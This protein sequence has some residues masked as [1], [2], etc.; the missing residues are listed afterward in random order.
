MDN[1]EDEFDTESEDVNSIDPDK[2]PLYKLVRAAEDDA[3]EKETL[4]VQPNRPARRR[5]TSAYFQSYEII[6]YHGRKN[7]TDDSYLKL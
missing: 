2:A 4:P 6:S 5:R 3:R 1:T 7:V